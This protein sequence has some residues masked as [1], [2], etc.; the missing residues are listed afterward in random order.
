MKNTED[1]IN[2]IG[3]IDNKILRI[4]DNPECKYLLNEYDYQTLYFDNGI[5][6]YDTKR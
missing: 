6:D 2:L 1:G 5:I 3:K 4:F